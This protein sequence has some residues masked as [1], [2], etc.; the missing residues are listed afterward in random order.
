MKSSIAE[1]TFQT[2]LVVGA[3]EKPGYTVKPIKEIE[4][5]AGHVA[6]AK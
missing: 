6:I 5:A 1:E 2:V 3:L 4:Y